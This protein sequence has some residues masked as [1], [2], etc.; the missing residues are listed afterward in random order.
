MGGVYS[1]LL[2]SVKTA[3]PAQDIWWRPRNEKQR[4]QAYALAK[5][6]MIV[7]LLHGETIVLSNNQIM[8]S[9]A[10]LRFAQEF[11]TSRLTTDVDW[12]LV[13]LG[14][15]YRHNPPLV[16]GSQLLQDLV[17][18]TFGRPDFKLSAWGEVSQEQRVQWAKAIEGRDVRA[19]LSECKDNQLVL[20]EGLAFT[21]D[22]FRVFETKHYPLTD[23]VTSP[24]H[25][26]LIWPRLKR[27]VA[28]DPVLGKVLAEEIERVIEQKGM[29]KES[30]SHIY[31]AVV[32]VVGRNPTTLEYFQKYIDRF[33]NEKVALSVSNGR[34]VCTMSDDIPET[35]IYVDLE[36]DALA[37]EDNDPSGIAARFVLK[38][39]PLE[40]P[41]LL[42]GLSNE[43]VMDILVDRDFQRSVE[44]L[45]MLSE[46]MHSSQGKHRLSA[47]R[48]WK[49]AV[50][51]HQ[52]WLA[53]QL[54]EKI[55]LQHFAKVDLFITP[56]RILLPIVA[57]TTGVFTY[58]LGTSS[59]E[60]SLITTALVSALELVTA[61]KGIQY[62]ATKT[63]AGRIRSQLHHAVSVEGEK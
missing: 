55:M 41:G 9:Y 62:L 16:H 38:H 2:D 20:A 42:R 1:D 34:A 43:D 12:P 30:R 44:K 23:F 27:A 51:K 58:V 17:V 40:S 37:D 48:R 4:A 59:E 54:G 6:D 63:A 50:A 47:Q 57:V 61:Y 36:S 5:A 49:D 8:D 15:Y 11:L 56:V 29:N 18:E 19:M 22:Y 52:E 46:E 31:E 10:W 28:K 25:P 33:Y 14:Y 32:S 21:Y 45:R 24:K 13:Q 35:D 26:R 60:N 39:Q 53:A 3:A 7:R